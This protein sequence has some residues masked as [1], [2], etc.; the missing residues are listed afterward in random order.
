MDSCLGMKNFKIFNRYVT[1]PPK[2]GEE[3]NVSSELNFP[4]SAFASF[5][6]KENALLDARG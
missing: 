2:K 6:A 4:V 3:S 1:D 5:T